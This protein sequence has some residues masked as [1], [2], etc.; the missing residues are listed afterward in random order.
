MKTKFSFVV[1]FPIIL[2]F[3]ACQKEMVLLYPDEGEQYAGGQTTFF[4]T[5]R[6][7]FSFSAP[8]LQGLQG[9]QFTTGNSFFNQSWVTAVAST[10]GRDGLGPLFNE[11]ACSGCHFKDGR[12]RT[13]RF[14]EVFGHGMLMRLSIPG[15]DANGGPLG[16][17]MYGDQL[18]SGGITGIGGEGAFDIIYAEEVGA[19]ADRTSYSLRKPTYTFSNLAYG[20][21]ANDIMISP[22]VANQ[23]VGMG[24]LEAIEVSSIQAYIDELD[25]DG[26]GISGKA[27][28]VY[29]VENNTTA[30]GRFGWKSGHPT[31]RQ[32]VAGAFIGDIG[33]TSS[34]FP[35]ENHTSLQTDCHTVPNGNNSNGYELD[36]QTLDRVVLYSSSL[37]VPG[38]RNWKDQEVLEGKVLF[39]EAGCQKC[40]VQKFVTGTHLKV[41][42]LSNQTIYPYTDLLLHDM[43]V[44]LADNRPEYLADGQ[45]WRTAPLW[46][47]GLIETVN[48]HT[49]FLHDGR[50]RNLEEA[51]LWHGG[52]GEASKEAFRNMTSEERYQLI[53]FIK[54]L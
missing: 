33:I 43:G 20:T 4:N 30:L 9:L 10:T 35:G 50:A 28:M 45:E 7:A 1:I 8:N 47:V 17:P 27:N 5:S 25:T 41:S 29:D 13:P 40:H 53:T 26:D 51:I 52:E 46:G 19:Y 39:M 15:V 36:D 23:M 2:L 16:A 11:V 3:T 18:S 48:E 31:V 49:E 24:L 34:L 32:Q 22:R 14:G 38:R 44:G 6:N 12:G 37:A 54:S 21:M 42:A